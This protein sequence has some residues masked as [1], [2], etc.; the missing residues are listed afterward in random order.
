MILNDEEYLNL[1]NSI[2]GFGDKINEKENII[3]KIIDLIINLLQN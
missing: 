2:I 3:I 1:K